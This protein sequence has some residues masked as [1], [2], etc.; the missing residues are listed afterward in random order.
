MNKEPIKIL[1]EDRAVIVIYKNAGIATQ[2]ANVSQKDCVSLLKEHIRKNTPDLKT[3]PYLGIVH[4]LDQS[5]EGILVF[6]K[7]R[8]AAAELSQQVQ[9][10]MM[11]K[12]YL[13]LV[14]GIVNAPA[15]TELSDMMY[16]DGKEKMAVIYDE[17]TDPDKGKSKIAGAT[18]QEAR[19]IY[20]T[21]SISEEDD[22]SVLSIR[23][24]TGRFHQ[25]RAQLSHMGHPIVGDKKYG[26]V[27]DHPEGIALVANRLEF[28]HPVTGEKVEKVVDFS[29]PL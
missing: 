6:A 15:D 21:C 1:Y 19:L 27:S 12:C 29:F 7:D 17:S 2:S 23:L 25:I 4:R 22:R 3:E 20:R 28:I 24:I 16:K 11:K 5:V 8:R 26:A 10:G 9:N 14:E 13:A 18:L